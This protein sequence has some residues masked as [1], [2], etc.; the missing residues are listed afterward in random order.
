M[1]DTFRRSILSRDTSEDAESAQVE[2]WRVFSAADKGRLVSQLSMAADRLALA[3]ITRRYPQATAHEQF[4]RLA[5][6]KLG[7]DLAARVY[8]EIESLADAR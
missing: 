6:L 5:I 1:E 7:R 3:G 2:R 4:L 8:P